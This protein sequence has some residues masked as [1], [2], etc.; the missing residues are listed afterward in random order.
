VEAL[1]QA[2]VRPEAVSSVYRSAPVGYA[3][4]PDFLNAVL[5]GG[6][7]GSVEA[8]LDAALAAEAAAGRRRSFRNAPRTLDIDLILVDGLVMEGDRLTIPHARWRERAF[9]LAP[10]AEVAPGWADPVTGSTVQEIWS[11]S[12]GRLPEVRVVAPPS[13]LWSLPT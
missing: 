7:P 4:Q 12:A 10:L 1:V 3:A 9:V 6:W 8:L 5:V 11:K 13:E 2:G